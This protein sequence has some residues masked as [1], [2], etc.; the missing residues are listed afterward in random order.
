M[1]HADLERAAAIYLPLTASII[2]RLLNGRHP[3]QFAA[4]LLSVLWTVP[5]LLVLQRFNEH[6]GW[7]SFGEGS[8]AVVRG[9][10]L[11]LFLGWVLLWG[12]IPQLALPRFGIARSA[13]N[14][15]ILDCILMPVCTPAIRLAAHWPVGEGVAV[16]IVLIP[17]LCIGGWTRR[18]VRLRLR[19]AT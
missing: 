3:R 16:V 13:I 5:S 9:M 4:C 10:P 11:E 7:W 17:A 18:N 15:I 1:D 2:A 12:L 6:V 14:M 19:A 8:A